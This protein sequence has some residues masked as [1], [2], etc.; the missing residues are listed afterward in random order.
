MRSRTSCRVVG[1]VGLVFLV[2]VDASAEVSDPTLVIRG[3]QSP[4]GRQSVTIRMTV[5]PPPA[6]RTH[7]T[8]TLAVGQ[9]V[10]PLEVSV[11]RNGRVSTRAQ[12]VTL[13]TLPDFG[14]AS[15]VLA[16]PIDT[17]VAF[18]AADC[19]ARSHG[20]I[21][22]CPG[23]T[24]PAISAPDAVYDAD[25]DR[26]IGGTLLPIAPAL[27]SIGTNLNGSRRFDLEL[28]VYDSLSLA[29][30]P[31]GSTASLT[32]YSVTGGDIVAVATGTATP[33]HGP[34][35][36]RFDGS[37]TSAPFGSP[38]TWSFTLTRP[39][40]GT[41]AALGGAWVVHFT[42]GGFTPIDGEATLDLTVPPDGH[43][44]T[45][46]SELTS[47]GQPIFAIGAGSCRVAPAGALWCSLPATQYY[48]VAMHGALDVASGAGSG[49]YYF[50]SPPS[51]YSEGT[52]TAARP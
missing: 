47:G 29:G 20:R 43:A 51:I 11:S 9:T 8:A 33:A 40:I 5:T 49:R 45:A 23:G 17:N 15:L 28:S 48:G 16:P 32:G 13:A 34:T 39:A 3:A 6:K 37:A 22:E 42:G 50:G 46:P 35:V 24:G 2:T 1:V 21:L 26:M 12:R 38:S 44:T 36:A 19:M 18:P 4:P 52:W 10:V 14:V 7:T 25:V 41:P 30:P 27:A 31:D